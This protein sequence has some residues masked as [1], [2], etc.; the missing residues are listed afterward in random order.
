MK[1]RKFS[2]GL[3]AYAIGPGVGNTLRQVGFFLEAGRQLDIEDNLGQAE[4]N[5]SLTARKSAGEHQKKRT[6]A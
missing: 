6:G 1:K 3:W 5:G 2:Q 4:F